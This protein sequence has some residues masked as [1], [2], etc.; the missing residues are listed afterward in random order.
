MPLLSLIAAGEE[1]FSEPFMLA[2]P[3]AAAKLLERVSP[4]GAQ[5]A[6]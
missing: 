5:T 6:G 4:P 3:I 2:V 1:M